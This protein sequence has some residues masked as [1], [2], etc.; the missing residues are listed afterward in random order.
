MGGEGATWRKLVAI[1]NI[2]F[3]LKYSK[4]NSVLQITLKCTP[5][6]VNR[7][8]YTFWNPKRAYGQN[9]FQTTLKKQLF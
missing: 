8:V 4:L 3:R 6:G 9:L 2:I 5:W 1:S 7:I